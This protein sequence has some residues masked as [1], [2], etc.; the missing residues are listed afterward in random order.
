MNIESIMSDLSSDDPNKLVDTLNLCI[1]Y[2]SLLKTSS[3]I[4]EEIFAFLGHKEYKI[5]EAAEKTLIFHIKYSSE[6]NE[7]LIGLIIDALESD[8]NDKDVLLRYT[9]LIALLPIKSQY[10][11]QIYINL[12]KREDFAQGLSVIILRDLC[13]ENPDLLADIIN[14]LLGSEDDKEDANDNLISVSNKMTDVK[15][16]ICWI[17]WGNPGLLI[18]QTLKAV[19]MLVDDEDREVRRLSCEILQQFLE[20]ENIQT[21]IVKILERKISDISWRVQKIAIE[22]LLS[23]A[24]K[25]GTLDLDFSEKILGLFWH[26]SWKI[27][28]NICEI[29]PAS[30]LL[31][32]TQ[33]SKIFLEALIAALDDP[34][35]E[36]RESAA[37][38]L[39]RN[40]NLEI[41]EYRD[42]LFKILSLT[43]DLHQE[44]RKTS[45]QIISEKF[46]ALHIEKELAFQKIIWLLQDPSS[47]VRKA[48]ID[49]ICKFVNHS[50]WKKYFSNISDNFLKLVIDSYDSVR[51]KA[52]DALDHIK[53]S[54]NKAQNRQ[55]F[56]NLLHLLE[57]ENSDIR[58]KACNFLKDIG[59]IYDLGSAI[60]SQDSYILDWKKKTLFLLQD[61]DPAVLKSAWGVILQ[62]KNSFFEIRSYIPKLIANFENNNPLIMKYVCDVCTKFNW[63]MDDDFIR[64][65]FLNELRNSTDRE[66]KKTILRGF[67][68]IQEQLYFD[69][70]ILTQL[71]QEG[72]WDVQREVIPFLASSLLNSSDSSDKSK[73][74]DIVIDMLEDPIRKYRSLSQKS[75]TSISTII[76]SVNSDLSEI[77]L[78]FTPLN[79]DLRFEKWINLEESFDIIQKVGHPQSE[80]IKEKFVEALTEQITNLGNKYSYQNIFKE[81]LGFET[82]LKIITL[83]RRQQ[84]PVRIRLLKEIDSNINIAEN[85]FKKL[86]KA[87]ISS[88]DDVSII[89]RDFAW[90]ILQKDLFPSISFSEVLDT[91]IT[92]LNS[93]HSDTRAK[94]ISIILSNI[95]IVEPEN[96]QIFDLIISLIDDSSFLVRN[97]VWYLIEK[98]INLSYPRYGPIV[99]KILKLLSHSNAEIR[100]RASI[101]VEK[102]LDTFMPIIDSYPQTSNV[103]HLLG[104]VQS[105]KNNYKEGISLLKKAIKKAPSQINSWIAIALT[106][107]LQR[108]FD[109]AI[110]ALQ[111]AQDIDPLNFRIYII[112]SECLLE[113]GK[114]FEAERLEQVALLLQQ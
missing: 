108:K 60:T 72:Q 85:Q 36:V 95:N 32:L 25:L 7:Q 26:P 92:L 15:K 66:L 89:I 45:C 24:Q 82:P 2:D 11:S 110:Q 22:S 113:S 33:G 19:S 98:K 76:E 49:A 105:K 102:R 20:S 1:V 109:E 73:F 44:V 43:N 101:T 96:E 107:I 114:Q 48:A 55:I 97:Q 99:R 23:Y 104:T 52:W 100:N 80:E 57:H 94:A 34:R 13:K 87:I 29:L 18:S 4:I 71:I 10:Y 91:I 17:F 35:W 50:F 103:Y 30:V 42:I 67:L 62:N 56:T 112:W 21:D 27:R 64:S 81:N 28:R 77:E 38:S 68:P 93:P 37:N 111:K 74:Q 79:D 9:K 46:E 58:L 86:R 41:V 40:L 75:I 31:T 8:E 54:Q 12:L 88:L 106:Y 39:N 70:Q 90:K 47:I 16:S 84:E 6:L 53:N 78:F 61:E 59:R 5:R 63:I 83:M 51:V 3:T 69:L 65:T 14:S